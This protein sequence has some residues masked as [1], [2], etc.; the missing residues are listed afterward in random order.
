MKRIILLIRGEEKRK[1]K[2]SIKRK[3]RI[4]WKLKIGCSFSDFSLDSSKDD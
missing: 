2:V 1:K 4:F 3:I